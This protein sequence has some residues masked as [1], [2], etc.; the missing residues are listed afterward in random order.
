M[1]LSPRLGERGRYLAYSP[2]RHLFG[3]SVKNTIAL[4]GIFIIGC[5]S[6]SHPGDADDASR[7]AVAECNRLAVTQREVHATET[8]KWRA[9]RIV[10]TSPSPAWPSEHTIKIVFR[11][12]TIYSNEFATREDAQAVEEAQ[13]AEWHSTKEGWTERTLWYVFEN[14]TWISREE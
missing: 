7:F 14:G 5:G 3:A 4:F 13:E 9:Q 2:A 1:C 12:K 10:R 11:Q 8:G 6:A